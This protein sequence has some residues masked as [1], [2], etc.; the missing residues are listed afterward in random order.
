MVREKKKF[1]FAVLVNAVVGCVCVARFVWR[2]NTVTLWCNRKRERERLHTQRKQ[3]RG[4][5]S[6]SDGQIKRK[7]IRKHG[8]ETERAKEFENYEF[9]V[10]EIVRRRRRIEEK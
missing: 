2:E 10:F 7:G 5:G 9:F 6:W 4:T 8:G 1:R 3:K